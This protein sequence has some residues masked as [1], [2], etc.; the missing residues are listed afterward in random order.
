MS[1][2]KDLTN[3]VESNTEEEILRQLLDT[4]NEARVNATVIRRVLPRFLYSIGASLENC[5]VQTSEEVLLRYAEKPTLGSA[6]MAQATFMRDTWK[7][8]PV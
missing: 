8:D 7:E 6:L 2:K 1:K 4:I 5:N 3:G